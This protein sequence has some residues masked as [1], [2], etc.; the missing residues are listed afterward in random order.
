LIYLVL[1]L[2][3]IGSGALAVGIWYWYVAGLFVEGSQAALDGLVAEPGPEH[4]VFEDVAI[5]DGVSADR[6]KKMSVK[7]R[8]G[9]IT[10][11][12]EAGASVPAAARVIAGD[13]RT[14][15][16]GL[17]DAHV[18]LMY[19]SGPELLLRAPAMIRAWLD[20]VAVYPAKRDD[21]VRRGQLKLKA[22]VTTMRIL[23]QNARPRLFVGAALPHPLPR[24]PVR[25]V[26]PVQSH[27]EFRSRP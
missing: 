1:F 7:V 4:L 16:P 24:S 5:W 18:H 26:T 14:L 2:A 25:L 23:H 9:R 19:D 13:G 15:M 20:T 22:G 11:I 17:I 8:S 12:R 3:L 6:R 10:S 27:P 21:I